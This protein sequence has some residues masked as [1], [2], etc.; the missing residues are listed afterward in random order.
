MEWGVVW[1]CGLACWDGLHTW[2]SPA[3]M[4][5]VMRFVQVSPEERS[6][7]EISWEVLSPEI[8]DRVARRPALEHISIDRTPCLC[9]FDIFSFGVQVV[10]SQRTIIESSPQSAVA[11]TFRLEELQAHVMG[12]TCPC[13]TD[14]VCWCTSCTLGQG[15]KRQDTMRSPVW[16]GSDQVETYLNYS[17]V[18]GHKEE[19]IMFVI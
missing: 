2:T 17:G 4:G 18:R 9:G 5:T 14:C 1:R 19:P 12:C 15:K 13:I 3:G 11:I 10:V 16:A 8:C 7:R 6:H